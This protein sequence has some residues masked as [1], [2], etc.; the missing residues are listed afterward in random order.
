MD[1]SIPV[2]AVF[3][4][5][6]EIIKL[7]PVLRELEHDPRINV[8]RISTG[9]QADLVPGFLAGFG[10]ESHESLGIMVADQP[11]NRLLA[12][13]I[14]SLDR[15]IEKYAPAAVVVQGDTTTALAGALSAHYRA[16]PVI[17]VEA[18]LRT[19]D[20]GSPFPEESNRRLISHV[21]SLHLAPTSGN[22]ATLIGEGIAESDIILT[23]NPVVD[24]IESMVKVAVPS[25]EFGSLLDELSGQKLIV[26]TAHRRE[27]FGERMDGYFAVVRD[28]ITSHPETVLVFPLHPNPVVRRSAHQIFGGVDRI[29]LVDPLGYVDFFCLLKTACLVLS[30]SGGVQ[31]E[32]ITLGKP[33]FILREKT[34]RPE[35]IESGSARLAP[36][37]Q[38]L[39][40]HLEAAWQPDSWC[41]RVR[42]RANPFGDG[43]SGP[44]IANAISR[45][46]CDGTDALQS[47]SA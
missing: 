7:T 44:R 5:R 38:A 43:R 6:P 22:V 15:V 4:T 12:N 28:F 27:N 9:Q 13:M 40:E 3:G 39:A 45:F 21:S 35:A 31:E 36:T 32:V 18:G 19:G 42:P 8:I 37:P 24:A 17:H 14:D 11:L 30:D 46:L 41:T 29:R 34:E 25:R 47:R 2:L 26:L 20:L 10:L 23:G 1:R 16:V 33:L